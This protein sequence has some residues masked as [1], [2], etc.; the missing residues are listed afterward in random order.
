MDGTSFASARPVSIQALLSH[1]DGTDEAISLKGRKPGPIAKDELLWVDLE[2]PS[3]D[4]LNLVRQTLKLDD[5]AVHSL[6]RVPDRPSA[7][8]HEG[9]A[10]VSVLD[11]HE[12][13]GGSGR[14]TL[15]ILVGAGWIVTN[16]AEQLPF[17][18]E[19][20]ER[21]TD[22]REV[23]R[24]TPVEFL[25]SILS[26][27]VEQ[28][29][30]AATALEAEVDRLDDAALAGER[31]LLQRLV[32]MRRRIAGLRRVHSLHREL[33]AEL[34]RPDFLPEAG[35]HDSEGLAAMADRLDRAGEAI[36]Y[37]REMLIGTFDVHMT[38]VA[39]RTNDVMRVLTLAS[40]ILLPSVVI[41]GIMGMNFKI[42]LFDN[43]NLFWVVIAV[44][45]ALAL[46]T[47]AVAR[48]RGWL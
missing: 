33:Y 39:Q 23:G 16:H 25:V 40:V 9:A 22:E 2:A 34:A 35:R 29:F 20:R 10:E 44:M 26:W 17:L 11:V 32:A 42:G 45:V 4:E 47:L 19:H 48:Q 3:A 5:R 7:I 12:E 27:H 13:G 37:V 43:P 14:A 24:L 38:R 28:F 1:D 46:G 41:A 30:S 8:V 36:S 6:E 18:A 15:Q 31:D 21:L